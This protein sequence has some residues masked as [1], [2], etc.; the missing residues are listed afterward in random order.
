MK[1][2]V[3][4]DNDINLTLLRALCRQ[5]PD[6]DTISFLNPLEALQWCREDEPDLVI[7]DYQMPELDGISFITAL[8]ASPGRGEVP[9][10]MITANYE[11][12]I[13]YEALTAGANDFLTKPLD[14]MEFL[15]RTRNMLAVRRGQKALTDRA[16]WL[17]REVERATQAILERERD[18]LFRLS[19][20]AEYRDRETGAHVL[21]IAHYSRLI[22]RHLGE[23]AALQELIFQAALLHDIGKVGTPDHILLKAGMLAPEELAIMREHALIGYEILRD[24]PSPILELAAT[25]AR[26]HH[27]RFDGSG[28]P[29]GLSGTAI[30][31]AGRIVAV[32]DVFDALTSARPYKAAWSLEA[33]LQYLQEQ[34]GRHFDPAC[35]QAFLS[36]PDAVLAVRREFNEGALGNGA[37]PAFQ[38]LNEPANPLPLVIRT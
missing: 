30:P 12:T 38:P 22:A 5:L 7:V 23:S 8:R 18:T 25:I 36:D 31:L 33:S 13:R 21:R 10:L 15:A 19:K 9:I 16:A 35:V 11:A 3:I 24:S 34:A 6:L 4:D 26:S 20:A 28:Y 17:S 2:V 29:D 1:V 14:R 32:A 27:E 37:L